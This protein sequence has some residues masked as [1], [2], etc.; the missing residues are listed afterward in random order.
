MQDNVPSYDFFIE[1]VLQVLAN[2]PEGVPAREVHEAAA[3]YL[4]L[5]HDARLETVS[6]GQAIYKNRSGWAHDRLKRAGLSESISRGVWCLTEK[7]RDWVKTH[8]FPLSKETRR[9]LAFDFLEVKL[10][11]E[12]GADV[13]P[14]NYANTQTDRSESLSVESPDDR[15]EEAVRT[16]KETVAS[17]LLTILK[18][19]SP[20]RFELIVLDRLGLEKV[21]VQAKRWQDTVG[22]PEIQAFYGALAGQKAKR[23]VFI[24]T[25]SYSKQAIEFAQSVEGVVLI[26]GV[27]L[28][29]LM[30]DAEVGVSSRSIKLPAIDSDYF[31]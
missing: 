23:G 17:E 22:R 21:Y 25:S 30:M 14:I 19:V 18:E 26:D 9:H 29:Y 10:T 2:C 11:D 13:S 7:G 4:D 15:L 27:Q 6:S 20:Q 31:D 5:S 3:D 16:I 1:P 24:T 12:E 28:V 8:R